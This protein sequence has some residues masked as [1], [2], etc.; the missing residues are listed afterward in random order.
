M[1]K[2]FALIVCLLTLLTLMACK[3]TTEAKN[4]AKETDIPE[5]LISVEDFTPEQIEEVCTQYALKLAKETGE[6]EG[7]VRLFLGD[8]AYEVYWE[9]EEVVKIDK[10]QINH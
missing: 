8:Y 4:S 5:T 10:V 2:L 3:P 7:C 1:K 6:K 9:N